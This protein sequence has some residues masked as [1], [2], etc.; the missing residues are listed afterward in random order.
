MPFFHPFGVIVYFFLNDVGLVQ[1]REILILVG[2]NRLVEQLMKQRLHLADFI[3]GI[4]GELLGGIGQNRGVF[5]DVLR[6]VA[7]SFQVPDITVGA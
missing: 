3:L 5:N 2:V 6:I 7:N 1:G 4:V